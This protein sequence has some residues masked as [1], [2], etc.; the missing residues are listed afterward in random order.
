MRKILFA[1]TIGLIFISIGFAAFQKPNWD[2][3]PE[4]K[5]KKNPVVSSEAATKEA[6]A[7]FADKCA[8]C[9][10]DAGKGDGPD[11]MMYDPGPADLTD[12]KRMSKFTD[13][14]LF[15]KITVGKKP[16]PSFEKRLSEQQRWEM[17]LLVRSFAN[18]SSAQQL[19]STETPNAAAASHH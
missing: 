4:M 19:D 16:M 2:A 6:K 12:A 8:N 11:A 17:V 5:Q 13:G 3:P 1:C 18:S 15:Y 7:I 14:D 10:G 9:H